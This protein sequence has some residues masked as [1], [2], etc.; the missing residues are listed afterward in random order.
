MSKATK[1]SDGPRARVLVIWEDSE[2]DAPR[3][4][5][6]GLGSMSV[7]DVR[8]IALIE[9]E[10]ASNSGMLKAKAFRYLDEMNLVGDEP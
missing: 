6:V 9:Q 10:P 4:W 5:A 2:P 3:T 1:S 8:L 7:D